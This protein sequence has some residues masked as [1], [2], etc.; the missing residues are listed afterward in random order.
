MSEFFD[1]IISLFGCGAVRRNQTTAQCAATK[2]PLRTCTACTARG[3]VGSWGVRYRLAARFWWQLSPSAVQLWCSFRLWPTLV[4]YITAAAPPWA[5]S[6]VGRDYFPLIRAASALQRDFVYPSSLTLWGALRC[7]PEIPVR[8]FLPCLNYPSS[9]S[10]AS[11]PSP[12]PLSNPTE[13]RTPPCRPLSSCLSTSP[14]G[15]PPPTRASSWPSSSA[16]KYTSPGQTSY[17]P[18]CARVIYMPFSWPDC[19]RSDVPGPRR[20]QPRRRRCR[21]RRRPCRGRVLVGADEGCCR[22]D[23]RAVELCARRRLQGLWRCRRRH[24]GQFAR[25]VCADGLLARDMQ[26]VRRWWDW[27]RWIRWTRMRCRRM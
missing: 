26:M 18:S 12:P 6:S 3:G 11:P 25:A 27:R 14:A 19:P 17:P 5:P 13:P 22:D 10:S 9:N 1:T 8:P 24:S 23:A 7:S 20:P 15:A 16:S 4:L 2:Q 21:G